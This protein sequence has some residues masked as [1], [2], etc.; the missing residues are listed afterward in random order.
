M[1]KIFSGLIICLFLVLGFSSTASATDCSV[2]GTNFSF[3]TNF[4]S[5][6]IT[7]NGNKAKL[8]WGDGSSCVVENKKTI[9]HD[10]AYNV[11]S[12]KSYNVSLENNVVGTITIYGSSKTSIFIPTT[13]QAPLNPSF[14]LP[15]N[16]WKINNIV[17]L[18]INTAIYEQAGVHFGVT[19]LSQDS[20][21][22]AKIIDGPKYVDTYT[23]WQIKLANGQTGW[24]KQVNPVFPLFN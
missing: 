24:I 22:L 2:N 10:Y 18:P 4:N 15:A 17:I 9:S 8:D 1:K 12:W 16:D 23:W 14:S 19:N 6:S 20:Y 5:L 7:N 13:P 21:W 11:D 3:S